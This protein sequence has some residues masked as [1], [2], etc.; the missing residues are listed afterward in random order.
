MSKYFLDTSV[1]VDFFNDRAEARN[2]I[3][4][5]E[6]E[7]TSAWICYAEIWEGI[8]K[9]PNKT[10]WGNKV[11]SFFESLSDVYGFD[12]GEAEI[13]GEIRESLRRR[14]ELIED[15]DIMIAAICMTNNLTLI[16]GNK[17]HFSRIKE[18]KLK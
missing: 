5:I 12:A 2:L 8:I 3:Q 18:L 16:T 11:K 1:I 10:E 9:K 14:G 4:E 13:F 17:K 7:L 15:L 6:G